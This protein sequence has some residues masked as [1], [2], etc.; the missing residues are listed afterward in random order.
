MAAKD[1][2]LKYFK[3]NAGSYIY[4]F[5]DNSAVHIFNSQIRNKRLRQQE[6]VTLSAQMSSLT[7][8]D[9]ATEISNE[10]KRKYG[11]TPVECLKLLSKGN[12]VF[13]ID[14]SG[15]TVG[16]TNSS[17]KINPQT[18]LPADVGY[19]GTFHNDTTTDGQY[20]RICN[21][22]TGD[23]LTIVNNNN[24]K[25][26]SQYNP[27]NGTYSNQITNNTKTDWWVVLQSSLPAIMSFF[28]WLG[29]LLFGKNVTA[30]GTAAVQAD[31]WGNQNG[32][33]NPMFSDSNK[34]LDFT[35]V[36]L[37][38]GIAYL[39]FKDDKPEKNKNRH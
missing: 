36:L 11:K 4:I 27:Q 23:P 37:I 12:R 19:S 2:I 16:A 17:V 14:G 28:E 33:P 21:T 7:Y 18:G 31:G 39:A 9:I 24:G 8:N 13:A 26:I 20:S 3:D 5:I 30:K 10:I 29:N 6:Y 35:T 34:G 32:K 15:A 38:G 25:V 1:K 22:E